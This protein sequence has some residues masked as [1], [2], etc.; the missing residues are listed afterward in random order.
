M[1]KD[2][3]LGVLCPVPESSQKFFEGKRWT[4]WV[5]GFPPNLWVLPIYSGASLDNVNS[6]Q[7]NYCRAKMSSSEIKKAIEMH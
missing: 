7:R 2:Y 5:E 6:F 4:P 1:G 3:L